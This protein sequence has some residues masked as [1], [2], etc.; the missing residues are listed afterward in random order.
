MSQSKDQDQQ[1]LRG[2]MKGVQESQTPAEEKAG[3]YT[4]DSPDKGKKSKASQESDVEG[5][6]NQG[7][8]S[9]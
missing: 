6:P 9:R 2:P 8:E 1:S 3:Q 4:G 5:S 7:T